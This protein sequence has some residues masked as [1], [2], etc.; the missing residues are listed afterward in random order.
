[1]QYMDKT[2]R[3]T[4]RTLFCEAFSKCLEL[5]FQKGEGWVQYE[6]PML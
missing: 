1:M 4:V 5:G 3:E 6:T 2:A